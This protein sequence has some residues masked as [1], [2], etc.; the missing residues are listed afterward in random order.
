MRYDPIKLIRYASEV[1]ENCAVKPET[2]ETTARVL[3]SADMRGIHSHGLVRIIGYV[4]CLQSGGVRADAVP[5]IRVEG[6]AF[7][8]V[9]ADQGLGI[10]ASVYANELAI[11]KAQKNGIAM[12]NVFNSHH[13]GACG[14]YAS[15]MADRGLL[16]MAMSTG[17]VIMASPG[18]AGRIIGNNPFSYAAPAGKHRFICFDAAM[19]A[20]AAG[21]ISM[22]A[23]EGH[24]IPVGWLKD[25]F[26]NDTT[27]P[28]QYN[29]GG[30]L[31]PFG[32]HKGFSLSVMVETFA[33][34]LSGAASLGDIHAWNK[35][36]QHS[37]NVGHMFLAVDPSIVQPSQD[38][39][40]RI[41]KMVDELI[42]AKPAPGVDR[43][44][45]PG[46]QEQE[47]EMKARR[48]GIELPMPTINAL[49]EAGKQTNI[50]F[51]SI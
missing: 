11:R 9:D 8:T 33:G 27:D 39:E 44:L 12:V 19:S 26:G 7:A 3:V 14:Y 37:G 35:D 15:E 50:S 21:K 2:A 29:L 34:L 32:G 45:Y 25:I 38:T 16:G 1:L 23:E 48:D 36:P 13:H 22:A 6:D 43:V 47:S 51:E 30:A 10:P 42:A 17:D 18:S 20:V 41:E 49:T 31:M 4:Q 24:S 46:Q 28:N 40:A 5:H